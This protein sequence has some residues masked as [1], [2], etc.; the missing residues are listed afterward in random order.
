MGTRRSGR[1][2]V[3]WTL[4]DAT[5]DDRAAI[6]DLHTRSW[7]ENYAHALPEGLLDARIDR[8]MADKWGARD[9]AAPDFGLIAEEAGTPLGFVYV[10]TEQNPPLIDNL[11]VAQAMQSRGIG[12]ALLSAAFDR[13]RA[14]GH[15]TAVLGVLSD[16]ERGVAFYT[17]MGGEEVDP[18]PETLLGHPII[19]RRMVFRLADTT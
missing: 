8:I 14:L 10:L 7:R 19:E 1:L 16:N 18:V 11:H 15:D 6:R 9:F 3:T 2:P 17:R 5:P 12:A 13:L 4:R